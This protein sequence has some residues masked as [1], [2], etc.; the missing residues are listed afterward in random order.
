MTFFRKRMET[1]QSTSLDSTT[2]PTAAETSMTK[3]T[4][5]T[6]TQKVYCTSPNHTHSSFPLFPHFRN[7]SWKEVRGPHQVCFDT[8]KTSVCESASRRSLASIS[9]PYLFPLSASSSA[10]PSSFWVYTGYW[11]IIKDDRQLSQ[12]ERSSG[13]DFQDS[14]EKSGQSKSEQDGHGKPKETSEEGTPEEQESPLFS[15]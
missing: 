6:F 15:E 10:T 13:S 7:R 14:G 2:P 3:T 4:R 12:S 8:A 9:L 5:F 11:Q 1:I